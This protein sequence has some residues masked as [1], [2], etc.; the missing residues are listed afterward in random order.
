MRKLIGLPAY[1]A[2][3]GFLRGAK[4][5]VDARRPFSPPEPPDH[6]QE[7]PRARVAVETAKPN[8]TVVY[9][10]GHL[11]GTLKQFGV[12]TPASASVAYGLCCFGIEVDG[13]PFFQESLVSV[14]DQLRVSLDLK[15][16]D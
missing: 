13:F 10:N 6:Q 14:P 5:D 7:P 2:E 3:G 4:L 16:P 1:N 9:T 12:S 15:L 8:L 11:P